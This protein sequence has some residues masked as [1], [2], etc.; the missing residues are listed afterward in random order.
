LKRDDDGTTIQIMPLLDSSHITCGLPDNHAT[1][2][3]DG[4]HEKLVTVKNT[5]TF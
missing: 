1:Y 5:G 3:I 2:F 4:L